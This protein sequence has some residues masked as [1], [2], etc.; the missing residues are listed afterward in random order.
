MFHRRE[1]LAHLDLTAE[2]F[3]DL[4]DQRLPRLLVLLHLAAWKLPSSSEVRPRSSLAE[5]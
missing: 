1:G 5:E 2:F 4:S 3:A